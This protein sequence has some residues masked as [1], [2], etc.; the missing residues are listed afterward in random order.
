MPGIGPVL[1]AGPLSAWIAAGL[2]NA[3]VFGGLSP[4]G[5]AIYSIGIAKGRIFSYESA[6]G[7]GKCLILAHG[8]VSEVS[9][10]RE[11]LTPVSR[12]R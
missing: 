6:V 1:V 3:P 4:L 7:E 2:E 12:Q 10:A 11:V 9:R 8:T 5:A